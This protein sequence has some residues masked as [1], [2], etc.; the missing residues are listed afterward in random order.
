MTTSVFIRDSKVISTTGK[1]NLNKFV[2]IQFDDEY[3]KGNYSK[4]DDGYRICSDG[5]YSINLSAKIFSLV[6]PKRGEDGEYLPIRIVLPARMVVA[7]RRIRGG[8][9][10][11]LAHKEAVCF[12]SEPFPGEGGINEDVDVE[13]SFKIK[14]G[15]EIR[16]GDLIVVEVYPV[17]VPIAVPIENVQYY[18]V[19][20]LGD[21]PAGN[22]AGLQR[23]PC[24]FFNVELED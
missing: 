23:A 3:I 21:R 9:A 18:S 22:G 15:K 16:C 6:V 19:S 5:T 17:F 4:R 1:D 7:I 2:R 14:T 12:R 13:I 24:S 20:M 8:I 10:K 11:S